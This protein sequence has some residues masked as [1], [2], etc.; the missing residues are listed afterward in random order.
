MI[1]IWIRVLQKYIRAIDK[2]ILL[3]KIVEGGSGNYYYEIKYMHIFMKLPE[4]ELNL[5]D[6]FTFTILRKMTPL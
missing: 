2:S 6:T 5:K 4:A 1:S 3:G